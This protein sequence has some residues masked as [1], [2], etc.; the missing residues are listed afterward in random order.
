MGRARADDE[1]SRWRDI[2]ACD[3]HLRDLKRE[4]RTP[5]P[6]VVARDARGPRPV[7]VEMTSGCGSPAAMC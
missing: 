2:R 3:A 1:P 7:A 5:P 4:R 6:D